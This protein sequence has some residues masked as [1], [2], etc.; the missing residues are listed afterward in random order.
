MHV[1]SILGG[2]KAVWESAG[3][4]ETPAPRTGHAYS[5]GLLLP[6]PHDQGNS[7]F[8]KTQR[9]PPY[10]LDAVQGVLKISPKDRR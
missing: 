9:G 6:L 4:Q 3:C 1:T 2:E 5:W 8:E 7:R 10:L